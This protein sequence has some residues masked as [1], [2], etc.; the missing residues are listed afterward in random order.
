MIMKMRAVSFAFA[1]GLLLSA[2][3]LQAGTIGPL[4]DSCFGGIYSLE[5]TLIDDSIS[6][7]ETWRIEYGLDLSGFSSTPDADY[8]TSLAAKVV[9]KPNLISWD[10][11]MP[12]GTPT[13][14][15][16][17]DTLGGLNSGDCS[18]SGGGWVC[19]EWS[20]GDQLLT[21]T[22]TDY[23]WVFDVTIKAGT[24]IEDA[25]SI[26]ANFGPPQGLLMSEKIA[27]PES[28]PMELPLLLTGLVA[29]ICVGRKRT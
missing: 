20:S 4:C 18:G 11:V 26:K 25:A 29:L 9:S 3:V 10:T 16:W 22:S 8:V 7:V 2:G 6:G 12:G 13:L 27:L 15:V 1:M 14:G 21:G 17:I 23:S 5:S 19:I 28:A 24:L